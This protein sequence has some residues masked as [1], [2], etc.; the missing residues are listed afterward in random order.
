MGAHEDAHTRPT[1]PGISATPTWINLIN[2]SKVQ[3]E[4]AP[5]DLGQVRLDIYAVGAETDHI[6]PRDAAWRIQQV[7][8]RKARYVLA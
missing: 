3:L 4:G 5:L 2:V 7:V 8:A 1:Q 6:V